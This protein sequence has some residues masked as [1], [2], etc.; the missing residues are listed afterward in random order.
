MVGSA[1]G[2]LYK[3]Q[4][5]RTDS[6]ATAIDFDVDT[7]RH[8]GGTPTIDKSWLDVTITGVPL[9]TGRVLVTPSLGPLNAAVAGQSMRF[10]LSRDSHIIGKPGPGRECALNFREATPGQDVQ[11][12]GYTME[13][14]ELGRRS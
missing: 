2:Y 1:S 14:F 4:A 8:D 9:A 10:D 7:K 13:F 11:I 3:D 5:T 12:T 6:T